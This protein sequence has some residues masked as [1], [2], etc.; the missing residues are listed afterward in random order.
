M[1]SDEEAAH[2]KAV[3][4]TQHLK[5]EETS[6]SVTSPIF[7]PEEI[8][9]VWV[10][11]CEGDV[12]D[13]GTRQQLICMGGYIKGNSGICRMVGRFQ[14]TGELPKIL[15]GSGEAVKK[16]IKDFEF[17]VDGKSEKK[18]REAFTEKFEEIVK[19]CFLLTRVRV[20]K[21]AILDVPKSGR[22]S[23]AKLSAFLKTQKDFNVVSKS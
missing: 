15:Q 10:G 1:L 11:I 3:L 7:D 8:D 6:S 9:F 5:L 19:E 22:G 18:C 17:P 23:R 21:Y 4:V 2:R 13:K 20:D 14:F 16:E 12:T